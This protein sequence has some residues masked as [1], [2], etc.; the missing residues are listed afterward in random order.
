MMAESTAMID[1]AIYLLCVVSG[2]VTRLSSICS[3][4]FQGNTIERDIL[5]HFCGTRR[6]IHARAK[7][8]A[9][10]ILYMYNSGFLTRMTSHSVSQV[11][12]FASS[13]MKRTR[14]SVKG[15]YLK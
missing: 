12:L 1:F 4:N 11:K 10:G 13:P 2:T 5:R 3:S 15:S 14:K 6:A 8:F 9:L 7:V